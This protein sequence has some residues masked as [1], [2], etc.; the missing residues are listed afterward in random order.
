VKP[1]PAGLRGWLLNL[2]RSF[3]NSSLFVQQT[4]FNFLV[5]LSINLQDFYNDFMKSIAEKVHL[6]I[7]VSLF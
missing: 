5:E 4:L 3:L 6:F 1:F 7:N 2:A